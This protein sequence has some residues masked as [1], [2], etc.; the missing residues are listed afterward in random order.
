LPNSSDR[1]ILDT[2]ASDSAIGAEILQI[3][4][5]QERVI[6]YGSSTLSAAQRRYC[7]TRKELLAVVR[8][9]QHFRHYLLGRE[10]IVR[11]DHSSLQWMM[12]F[13]EPQGQLARWLQV[14]S[15]YHM[16]IQHRPGRKHVNA[17]V[18]SR[19]QSEKPCKEM[20]IFIPPTSLPCGGCKHCV[21]RHEKMARFN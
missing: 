9:T 18:L 20:S 12:N 6:A 1:F 2:D 13:K 19:L 10:F 8:F 5:D 3:Q 16:Q 17:D 21:K 14:L 4:D 7:T 15:H 11:T